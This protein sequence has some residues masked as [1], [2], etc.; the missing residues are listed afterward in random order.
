MKKKQKIKTIR[1]P[2]FAPQTLPRMAVRTELPK[3]AALLPTYAI[4]LT[5]FSA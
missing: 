5:A 4:I 2:P 3:P 1:Q